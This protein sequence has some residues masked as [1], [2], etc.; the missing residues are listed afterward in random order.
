M[1]PPETKDTLFVRLVLLVRL[2]FAAPFLV[3]CGVY[4]ELIDWS[5]KYFD[6]SIN[7][8]DP[9]VDAVALGL[10]K[11]DHILTLVSA[12]DVILDNL[13]DGA[14]VTGVDV[15]PCQIALCEMK[16]VAIQHLEYED[17]FAI[18]AKN[19]LKLLKAK[20]PMLKPH[21]SPASVKV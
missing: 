5:G 15:N 12:G 2:V 9:A 17:F 20:F 6:F 3:L 10:N 14:R 11:D 4:H 8:E 19:D 1:A 16:L 18:F 21:M 7:W 13:I